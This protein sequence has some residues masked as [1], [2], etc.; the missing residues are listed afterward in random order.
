[1]LNILFDIKKHF[2][3]YITS[4]I[5]ILAQK[6]NVRNVQ[7]NIKVFG[8]FWKGTISE[9]R[10]IDFHSLQCSTCNAYRLTHWHPHM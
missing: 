2:T 1:M 4:L 7:H 10:A 8:T 9:R 6:C 3:S 5:C